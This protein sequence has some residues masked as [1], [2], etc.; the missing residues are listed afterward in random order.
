MGSYLDKLLRGVKQVWRNGT[1]MPP[2]PVINF[3]NAVT[4]VD[5]PSLGTTDVYLPS[6][7]GSGGGSLLII[8]NNGSPM[9][10]EPILNFVN[11]TVVDEPGFTRTTVSPSPA[12]VQV[13]GNGVA[14]TQRQIINFIGGTVADNAPLVRTDVTL[15]AVQPTPGASITT[16][17]ALAAGDTWKLFKGGNYTITQAHAV[18]GVLYRLQDDTTVDLS[19]VTVVFARGSASYTIEDPV[20]RAQSSQVQ[21]LV[22][23]A[24]YEYM[25]D[26]TTPPGVLRCMRPVR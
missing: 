24:T 19:S 1:P 23:L 8:E 18:P 9:P 10:S 22:S 6:T 11:C 13:E 5:N 14:V 20:T 17:V 3:I 12:Y 7:G 26:I 15:A 25:L 21:F 2:E 4:I 16:N